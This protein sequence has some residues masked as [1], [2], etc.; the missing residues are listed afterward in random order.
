MMEAEG[1]T[2]LTQRHH[3]MQQM[4]RNGVQ[5][6]GL[7]L[8]VADDTYA[9]RAVTSVYPPEG[10]SVDDIR[11][12]L[13]NDFGIVVANGQKDLKG[14]IFRIGHLGYMSERDVLMTLSAL[15][16]TLKKLRH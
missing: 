12:G 16:V 7:K 13:K 4:V 3:T 15:R 10:V 11:A 6:L 1:M 9:S 2:A 14:K 8:V 5:E